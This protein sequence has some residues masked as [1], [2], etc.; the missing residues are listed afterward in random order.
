MSW[1]TVT[2]VRDGAVARVTLNS[3]ET[4]NML[5]H[6]MQEELTAALAEAE[7][8]RDVRVIVIGGA[9]RAFCAG[10][11]VANDPALAGAERA[12]DRERRWDL[13]WFM[14]LRDLPKP[15]IAQVQGHCIMAGWMLAMACDLIVASD[16]ALFLENGPRYASNGV[17]F[18]TYFADLGPRKTKEI[19]FRGRR[20]PAAELHRLGMITSVVPRDQLEAETMAIA[21]EIA[22]ADPFLLRLAKQ[23][24]NG[25]EDAAGFRTTLQTGMYLHTLSG[26]H[27]AL[28]EVTYDDARSTSQRKM[29]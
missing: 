19:L 27:G 4:L 29:P 14:R 8:D 22:E 28:P 24:V 9:G 3:P 10:H 5:T 6:A 20:V 15:T 12:F 2:S 18:H 7:A 13:D 25:A 16:D 21:R 23:T 1:N 26:M 11:I 17:S